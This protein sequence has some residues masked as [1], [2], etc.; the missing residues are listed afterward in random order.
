M[1][2]ADGR[3]RH[4]RNSHSFA[5]DFVSSAD[6]AEEMGSLCMK[7]KKERFYLI[8]EGVTSLRCVSLALGSCFC[9]IEIVRRGC[10]KMSE[11]VNQEQRVKDTRRER[12][13]ERKS[14]QTT[15][16]RKGS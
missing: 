10:K 4:Q 9:R 1:K 6:L 7:G 14:F 3:H 11:K 2:E 8:S 5:S 16:G 12:E 15:K 13:S